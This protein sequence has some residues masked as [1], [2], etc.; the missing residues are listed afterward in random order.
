MQY[1]DIFMHDYK[2][3]LWCGRFTFYINMCISH[4]K[5]FID[6]VQKMEKKSLLWSANRPNRSVTGGT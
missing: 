6:S 5:S 2:I 3:L 4:A 1:C